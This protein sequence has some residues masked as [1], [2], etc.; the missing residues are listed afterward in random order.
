MDGS[1]TPC[2][3]HP[4]QLDFKPR[5]EWAFGEKIAHPETTARADGILAALEARSERYVVRAPRKV[6]LTD[7]RRL[8]NFNLLTL[9]NTARQLPQGHTF[10]PSV[11][12]RDRTVR[13]D[14]TN[15][16]HAGYFCF[17][18]GTPLN[19]QTWTAATWSAACAAEAADAVRRGA[20]LAFALSRPPGHHA[21]REQFGGYCYFNNTAVAAGRLR[22]N[23][24]V[25]IVDIDF[26]HGNGTQS[27]FWRDGRVLTISVHGDPREFFP[28]FVGFAAET[29]GAAGRGFNINLPL[30]AK[31]DGQEYLQVLE[32]H[33]LPA[34]RHFDPAS[35]V[36]AAGVDTYERDP[37]GDFALTTND[38][39]TVGEVIGRLKLPTA[40]IMEGGYYTPHIGRNVDALLEGLREGQSAPTPA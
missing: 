21:T 40:A 6:P 27:I 7:L 23:G 37:I 9:Y 11:F 15:I 10:Y 19:R 31:T 8:H 14:P 20:K 24:R 32:R 36:M 4:D 29:G 35:L 17:D 22:R 3:F 28:F 2:F 34:I 25:A 1:P 13:V 26:H 12:L 39:R 33:V 5:Y 30:P 18:S 38:L 16:M